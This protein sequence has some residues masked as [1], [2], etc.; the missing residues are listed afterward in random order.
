MSHFFHE[1]DEA[2]R[3]AF[4]KTLLGQEPMKPDEKPLEKSIDQLTEDKA[5]EIAESIAKEFNK[6]IREELGKIFDAQTVERIGE[7]DHDAVIQI[8]DKRLFIERS[9]TARDDGGTFYFRLCQGIP[10]KRLVLARMSY[11]VKL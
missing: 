9:Y 5:E 2:E 4:Y 1:L 11:E 7:V 10:E 8:K 3:Q 6:W